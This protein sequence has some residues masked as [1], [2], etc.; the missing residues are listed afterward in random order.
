LIHRKNQDKDK[1][2]L[3]VNPNV[4]GELLEQGA[5][6]LANSAEHI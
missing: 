1:N 5:K 4:I 3:R 6:V 2:N